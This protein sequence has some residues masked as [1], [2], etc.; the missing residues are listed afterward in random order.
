MVD[1]LSI[2]FHDVCQILN[3]VSVMFIGGF[4]LPKVLLLDLSPYVL[5]VHL[6]HGPVAGHCLLPTEVSASLPGFLGPPSF[7][8][9]HLEFPFNCSLF[10]T[11]QFV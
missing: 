1:S 11:W 7:E 8:I 9:L 2:R 5:I 10:L 6:E 4:C 3:S